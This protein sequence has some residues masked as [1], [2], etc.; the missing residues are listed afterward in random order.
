MGQS[1]DTN[2]E[3]QD[4]FMSGSAIKIN[5]FPSNCTRYESSS[6]DDYSGHEERI[7]CAAVNEVSPL[8]AKSKISYENRR[9]SV[10]KGLG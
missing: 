6:Q 1:G 5:L 9:N 7:Q 8:L 2:S 4:S 10:A 3:R